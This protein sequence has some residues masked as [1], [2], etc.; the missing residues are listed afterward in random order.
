MSAPPPTTPATRPATP[1]TRR[2]RTSNCAFP[3]SSPRRGGYKE[4]PPPSQGRAFA[5]PEEPIRLDAHAA[6]RGVA[7]HAELDVA[8]HVVAVDRGGELKRHRHGLGDVG[9]PGEGVPVHLPADLLLAHLAF[10]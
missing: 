3:T 4:G 10:G 2:T 1:R 5:V 8:V 7:E 6:E 9:A